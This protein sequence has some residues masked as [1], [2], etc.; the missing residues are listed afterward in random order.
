HLRAVGVRQVHA[1]LHPGPARFADVGH[2]PAERPPRPGPRRGRARAHPQPR[3]R[4]RVP[5]L[6]PHRRPDRLR[7]RRAAL[8]LPRPARGRAGHAR[9][10]R[11]GARGHGPPR[12]PPAGPALRRT[13]AARGGGARAGGPAERPARR[14]ADGEPRLPQRRGRH[15]PAARAAPRRRDHLHGHARPALHALRGPLRPS[16]R[17]ARG[18]RERRAAAG[19]RARGRRAVSLRTD[20]RHAVRSLAADRGWTAVA[21][22]TVALGIGA[23]AA[24]FSVVD[25]ALLRPLPFP[26][27]DRIVAVWGTEAGTGAARQRT[28]YPDL[29]DFQR[30]ATG[31]FESLAAYQ[32]TRVTLTASGV[33]P[34]RVD[35]AAVSHDLFPLL[36][37]VP[38]AGR[39]FTADEDRAGGPAAVLLSE[40][41]WRE[42]WAG[43]DV[44]GQTITVEAEPHTVVGVMPASFRFPADARLWTPAGR[45]PRNE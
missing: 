23:N 19:G 17:R 7:E 43:R 20:L 35:A 6:Q 15:G 36:R 39:V 27:P 4:V 33:E 38:V 5:E 44:I 41:L 24:I 13:A 1:A 8:E 32:P 42:R 21:V 2:L 10:D 45:Q 40:S 34:I 26:D 28:S 22:A 11:A 12:G 14:R 30:T 31:S 37:Q 9:E 18:G 16:L 25:A 29:L 3:D